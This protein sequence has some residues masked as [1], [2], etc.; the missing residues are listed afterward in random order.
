[1]YIAKTGYRL[2]VAGTAEDAILLQVVAV[3]R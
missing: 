3:G 2:P 1:M